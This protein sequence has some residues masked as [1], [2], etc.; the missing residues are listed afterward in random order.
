MYIES[1]QVFR[2]QW[3]KWNIPG[4]YAGRILKCVLEEC[5]KHWEQS[6]IHIIN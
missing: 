3:R 2:V 5:A 6:L 4:N 1:G